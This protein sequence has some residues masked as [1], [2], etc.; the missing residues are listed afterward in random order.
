MSR[1]DLFP[2][3]TAAALRDLELIAR[4][5]VEGIRQGAHRSPFHGFSS[6]FSQYRDYRPG[7]DLKYVDWKAFGRSDRFYTRQ[8]RETTNLSA[9]FVIDVSRSMNYPQGV[10]SKFRLAQEVTA[11]LGT[12]VMDQGDSAGL[13]A[14]GAATHYL[15]ARGGRQHLRQCLA[16]VARLE[17]TGA[18][19]IETA[20]TR[21]QA[22]LRR[23]GLVVAVSDWY[24]EADALRA[25]RRLS[26]AGHD[27]LVVHIVA[28]E[29]FD[30]ATLPAGEF[31][32]L[33]TGKMLPVDPRVLRSR[34]QE[35]FAQFLTRVAQA[36]VREG[37]EYLRL[38]TG[39]PLEPAIRRFLVTRKGLR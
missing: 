4:R 28:R 12:L 37:C 10:A 33:E 8:F 22:L 15:P 17:P 20:L 18:V 26:R 7:D 25:L 32:D 9:L 38:V 16:R 39:D 13:L 2:H 6:E 5:T 11:V 19:H 14:V 24:E 3:A 30:L 23:R 36:T 21:A 29:E 1:P 27:V 31:V 35:E 34:Y